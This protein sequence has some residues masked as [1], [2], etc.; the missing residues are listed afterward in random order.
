MKFKQTN[1]PFEKR[2][3][4]K[5]HIAESTSNNQMDSSGSCKAVCFCCGVAHHIKFFCKYNLAQHFQE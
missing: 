2:K 4:G 3:F 1:Q 5:I